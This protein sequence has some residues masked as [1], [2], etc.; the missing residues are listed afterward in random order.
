MCA[1]KKAFFFIDNR[2]KELKNS[3]KHRTQK[4]VEKII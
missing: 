3:E 4:G 2:K 1:T